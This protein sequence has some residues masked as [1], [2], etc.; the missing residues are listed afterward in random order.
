MAAYSIRLTSNAASESTEHRHSARHSVLAQ[1]L[2]CRRFTDTYT[3]PVPLKYVKPATKY[4]WNYGYFLQ[5]GSATNFSRKLAA[6]N[7][8]KVVD[9]YNGTDRQTDRRTDRSVA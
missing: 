8:L 1:A 3:E 5:C 4:P 2:L 9:V 7:I 6:H